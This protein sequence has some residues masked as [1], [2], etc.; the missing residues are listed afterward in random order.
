MIM[1]Q[2]KNENKIVFEDLQ[3]GSNNY[4]GVGK[5]PGQSSMSLKP[6]KITLLDLIKQANDWENEMGKAPNRLPYPLQDGLS[7]QIGDLYVRTVEIKQKVAES[8]K[9]SI[10]K[11]KE[12]AYK[13]GCN[14]HRKLAAI[15][16]A[17]KEVVQDLDGLGVGSAT[18]E[19]HA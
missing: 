19:F 11:D 8:S 15:G 2:E 14:I 18:K 12:Q 17:I 10:I 6:N 7:E 9:Y 13:S 1:S 5:G 3:I 16:E 4:L